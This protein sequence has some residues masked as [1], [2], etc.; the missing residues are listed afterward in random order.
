MRALILLWLCV[1]QHKA[2]QAQQTLETQKVL[3]V[4]IFVC[5]SNVAKLHI[6]VRGYALTLTAEIAT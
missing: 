6:C 5:A 1:C 3:M 2:L 4:Y